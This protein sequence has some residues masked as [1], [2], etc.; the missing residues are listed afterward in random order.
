MIEAAEKAKGEAEESCRAGDEAEISLV[1]PC[2][3]PEE[4][5]ASRVLRWVEFAG[6]GELILAVT[7][8]CEVP[9]ELED[10]ERVQVVR[11]AKASRGL[12]MNRGAWEAR[13]EIIMFHH[14]DSE[15]TEEHVGSVRRALGKRERVIGGAFYRKFDQR[16]AELRFL[17][18]FER[19]HCWGFGTLYGDQS[20]FV[21][22]EAFK[23]MG[24]MEEIPL[25]E[26]VAF[27]KRL[28]RSGRVI[29]L[30]PPMT[31]SPRRHLERGP[32]KMTL[33]NIWLLVLFRLGVSPDRLHTIYYR[34]K[35]STRG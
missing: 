31:S 30:D 34:M 1:V 14:L 11:T 17:E 29:L 2:W 28:R 13:C 32:W 18:I 23:E 5:V 3:H 4:G 26:D 8:E 15:L 7:D 33:L 10:H 25:M 27:S 20:V 12:Q 24:G 35:P 6:V 9:D 21:R 16:H 22:R 19:W